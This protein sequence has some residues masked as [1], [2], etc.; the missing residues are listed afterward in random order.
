VLG[1]KEQQLEAAATAGVG[2]EW[3]GDLEF[4]IQVN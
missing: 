2:T 3:A 1:K 4:P